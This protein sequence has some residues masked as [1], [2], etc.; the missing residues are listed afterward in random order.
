MKVAD[1][2][3]YGRL[4]VA[5]V[6]FGVLSFGGTYPWAYWPLAIACVVLGLWGIRATEAP[7][8][9]RPGAVGAGLSA[10]AAVIALQLVPLPRAVFVTL[11]PA[12]DRFLAQYQFLYS[13]NP[14][15][16][17]ALS[18]VPAST[19]V[20]FGLFVAFG[21][22]LTGLVRAIDHVRI[23]SLVRRLATLGLIVA[24]IGLI[25]QAIGLATVTKAGE[26]RLV[27]G[28]WN[29]VEGGSPFGPFINHNHF[30]GW[31][32]MVLPLAL[33]HS[34]AVMQASLRDQS[35][36]WDRWF[37]WLL[38]PQAGRFLLELFGILAMGMS[39]V[40]T[41][42]R[43]GILGFT[44]A[45]MVVAVCIARR[46]G[47]WPGRVAAAL[48]VVVLVAGAIQWAG[49][50]T[51]VNRLMHASVD[52][53]GRLA[54]WRDTAQ[55][56]RDFPIV[57]TGV[58]TYGWAM[59]V[60]QTGDR[61]QIFFEAHN[62]YLQ[63]LAEGG[64]LLAVPVAI[65]LGAIVLVIRRRFKARR[66][67]ILTYWIRVGAVAGLS[68]VAVQSTLEFSLQLMGNFV[69]FGLIAAI[70]M[71]AGRPRGYDSVHSTRVVS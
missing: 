60:Y 21:I 9:E 52:M 45:V 25:Q 46:I 5:I 16:W 53:P 19:A 39:L 26:Q 62:D 13:V 66:D 38:T 20:S 61:S 8:N 28:F 22:F 35:G 65:T 14:P 24:L 69:L 23:D 43:S 11:S 1:W 3:L 37:R 31:I 57:G 42:S 12:A 41:G 70:A 51:T 58:G 4:L 67:D 55:I 32:M 64:I 44:I 56:I 40:L 15:A 6:A 30:A 48:A 18:I 68:G 47:G 29:P 34:C 17:H 27:Y 36:K 71:H 33:G 59:L 10:I 50:D 49:V 7:A 63:I 54:A 2:R